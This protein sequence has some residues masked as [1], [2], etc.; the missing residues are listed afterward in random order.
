MEKVKS[1]KEWVFNEKDLTLEHPASGYYV[2]LDRC[3]STAEVLDWI[4]QVASKPWATPRT[5][6]ALVKEL[7]ALL[8][9]QESYCSGGRAQPLIKD[10][11]KHI[12]KYREGRRVWSKAVM[13]ARSK[14]GDM[15]VSLGD[16]L[17]EVAKEGSGPKKPRLNKK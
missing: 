12:Q 9:L 14:S 3:D 11:R 5:V 2:D 16:V 8:G 15:G 13:K 1:K 4:V 6:G 17:Q 7:D 10:V